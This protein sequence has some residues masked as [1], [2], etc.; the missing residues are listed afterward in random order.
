[1]VVFGAYKCFSL[2]KSVWPSV[3]TAKYTLTSVASERKVRALTHTPLYDTGKMSKIDI[4]HHV[5]QGHLLQ[6]LWFNNKLGWAKALRRERGDNEGNAEHS[7]LLSVRRPC[8]SP[9]QGR[10]ESRRTSNRLLADSRVMEALQPHSTD[11][12]PGWPTQWQNKHYRPSTTSSAQARLCAVSCKA[13]GTQGGL[14][15]PSLSLWVKRYTLGS[16]KAI[17]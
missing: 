14:G 17:F 7:L 15:H 10:A 6:L 5:L 3:N 2:S 16:I 4:W 12:L 11:P 8:Q 1:M 9:G 13:Q